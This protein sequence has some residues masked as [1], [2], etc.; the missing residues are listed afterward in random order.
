VRHA[1]FA[2]I[3]LC[4][5]L[6]TGPLSAQPNPQYL[7]EMGRDLPGASDPP[8]TG[9]YEG[10]FLLAQTAKAFDEIELPS[11]AA[12]GPTYSDKK[13]FTA[14]VTVSGRV[15]RSLY[16]APPGR[17]T[18]EIATNYR[19]ALAAKGFEPVF[20]CARQACGESFKI[21]KYRWDFPASHVVPDNLPPRR[22]PI[23]KAMFNGGT[24]IRYALMKRSD[25]A[26]DTLAAVFVGLNQ[27]GTFGDVSASLEGR[28]GVL[29]EIVE[30]RAMERRI[31]TVSAS[32]IGTKLA[33]EGRVAFYGIFFDF[34]KAEIKPQS[35]P[36][37]AEMAKF[38]KEK[39][40]ARVFVVGHT[41]AKGSLDYNLSLSQRRAEAVAKALATRY[42]ID[43]KRFTARGL[44]PLAPLGSNRTEEGQARNRRVELVE[45]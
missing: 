6:D 19:D 33:A 27:G 29:V 22:G 42:A 16:V 25:S 43:P 37:L 26:G 2:V 18:L 40:Q 4:L 44:G 34:D 10:S 32:E 39:P 23:V 17:S 31:V 24:D 14:T 20:E 7:A 38:L 41:D 21:L 13:R 15:L 45:Q 30:P 36:Q 3:A 9:R 8:L 1:L 35:D 11:G 28:P 12:E 5:A